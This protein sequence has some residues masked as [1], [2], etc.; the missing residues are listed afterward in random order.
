MITDSLCFYLQNRLIQTG[1][2]GGQRYSDTSHFSIPWLMF[3]NNCLACLE[4]MELSGPRLYIMGCSR[5]RNDCQTSPRH[6][7]RA[8]RPHGRQGLGVRQGD[9]RGGQLY[10]RY[11]V[12]PG[13]C[14]I[15]T[16]WNSNV[17]ILQ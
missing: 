5:H 15:K 16:L 10:Q 2:R 9:G 11:H 12:I 14:T 7:C 13:S 1:Q 3:F 17:R 4:G 6:A 8:V